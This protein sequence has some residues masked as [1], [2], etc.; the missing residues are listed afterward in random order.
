VK[1]ILRGGSFDGKVI[2]VVDEAQSIQ[3]P[4]VPNLSDPQNWDLSD[5]EHP[6]PRFWASIY[7]RTEMLEDDCIVFV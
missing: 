7:Y 4:L 5:P 1:C 3:L 6:V 2:T